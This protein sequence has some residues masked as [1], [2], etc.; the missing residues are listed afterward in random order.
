M[1]SPEASTPLSDRQA[2]HLRHFANL[3][4][5]PVNDWSGMQGRGTGQDDFG[6]Y[7]F[8]LAYM[9]YAIALAHRH[10]LPAA[11]GAFLRQ[12]PRRWRVRRA[13]PA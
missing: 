1:N 4:R 13:R 5:R 2:G 11:P 6:G 8:Q 10:R 9:A 12:R 7:R 3:S